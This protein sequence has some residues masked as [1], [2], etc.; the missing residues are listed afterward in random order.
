MVTDQKGIPLFVRALDG[1][2]SNKKVLIK[3]I[4]ELTQKL[5]QK[6]TQNLNLDQRV[7]HVAD[8][9]FYMT[10]RKTPESLAQG[11]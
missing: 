3:T 8:S 11:I 4:K 1:N 7:C 6:L 2:S 10:K 5:T 9:A